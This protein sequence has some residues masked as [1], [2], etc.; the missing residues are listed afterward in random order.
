MRKE[1]GKVIVELMEKDPEI[2]LISGDIGHG[3]FDELRRKYPNRFLN[4]G[5]CE[6]SMVS[7]ASGMALEGLKPWVYTITTFLVERPYEQV[8]IDINQQN[9][10]V[11]LVGYADYPELGPTHGLSDERLMDRFSNI[12]CY[13]PHNSLETRAAAYAAY[14]HHGPAFISL[15]EDKNASK[16]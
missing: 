12:R 3:V 7:V 6:Q 11:K 5:L 13:Y 16:K 1:F 9:A 10:N 4:I 14:E 8:K 2:Y 15:K